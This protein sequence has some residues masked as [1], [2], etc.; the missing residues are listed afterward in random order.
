M[1]TNSLPIPILEYEDRAGRRGRRGPQFT[2][3]YDQRGPLEKPQRSPGLAVLEVAGWSD[4]R[5]LGVVP[6]L[7]P[8]SSGSRFESFHPTTPVGQ[9]PDIGTHEWKVSLTRKQ[10]RRSLD[11]KANGGKCEARFAEKSTNYPHESN[12]QPST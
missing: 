10:H 5:R 12:F 6:I 2:A 4:R 3:A 7:E 8:A 1:V 11:E 9:I